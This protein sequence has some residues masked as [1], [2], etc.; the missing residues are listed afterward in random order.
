MLRDPVEPFV[1]QSLRPMSFR[2]VATMRRR[3]L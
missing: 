3:T 2:P 1:F